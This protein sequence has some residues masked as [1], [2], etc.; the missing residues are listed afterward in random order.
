MDGAESSISL[1]RLMPLRICVA[2]NSA[3][4]IGEVF[5]QPTSRSQASIFIDNQHSTP[6]TVV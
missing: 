2:I 6:P 3:R 1:I 4:L 5:F